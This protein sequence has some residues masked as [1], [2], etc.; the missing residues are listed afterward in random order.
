MYNVIVID[1]V[2]SIRNDYQLSSKE[3]ALDFIKEFKQSH[4]WLD[5]KLSS[6]HDIKTYFLYCL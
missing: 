5:F 3:K 6:D 2:N 1:K 4:S